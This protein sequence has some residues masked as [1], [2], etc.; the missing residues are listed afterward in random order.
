MT[1]RLRWIGLLLGQNKIG[2]GILPIPFPLR[3]R[4]GTPVAHGASRLVV[5]SSAFAFAFAFTFSFAFASPLRRPP[6]SRT[7]RTRVGS[8]VIGAHVI[9][10]ARADLLLDVVVV[11]PSDNDPRDVCVG[12]IQCL[13]LGGQ[14]VLEEVPLGRGGAGA[15][16]VH[17]FVV[18]ARFGDAVHR[19]GFVIL[20]GIPGLVV[21]LDAVEVGKG[22]QGIA[23]LE[24]GAGLDQVVDTLG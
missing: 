11:H 9:Q 5:A 7:V 13:G 21:S 3:T 16:S 17:R 1:R 22:H 23:D 19:H 20:L 2:F 15:H 12:W 10:Q 8:L 4:T 6:S 18:E 24:Q 14:V